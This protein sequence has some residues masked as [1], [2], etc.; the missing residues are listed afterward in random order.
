[1][2]EISEICWTSSNAAARGITSLPVEVA[3]ARMCE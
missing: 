2:A 1:M 3:G